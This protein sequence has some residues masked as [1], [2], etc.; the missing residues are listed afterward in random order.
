MLAGESPCTAIYASPLRRAWDT[1]TAAGVALGV[2]PRRYDGLREICCGWLDGLQL[3]DIR[4]RFPTLWHRNLA[5]T[6]DRFAWPGGE[7]YRAFRLRVVQ[8]ISTLASAH[9][10][11]RIVLVTH[12]GVI[13]QLLGALYGESAARWDAFRVANASV[14]ELRWSRGRRSELVRFNVAAAVTATVSNCNCYAKGA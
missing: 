1:A 11:E 14:S 10:G 5:Q 8:A 7:S 13:T 12:A 3:A 2:Q 6:D 4:A 9:V